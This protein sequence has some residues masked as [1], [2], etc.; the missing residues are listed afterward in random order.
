MELIRA[1]GYPSFAM[2]HHTLLWKSLDAQ[3][4]SKG[5]GV[6]VAGKM[7]HWYENWVEEVRKHCKVNKAKYGAI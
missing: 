6:M 3:S 4:A 5:Y 1:E 2:H 7:W